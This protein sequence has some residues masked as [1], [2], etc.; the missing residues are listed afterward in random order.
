ME[1]KTSSIERV[2]KGIGLKRG[3]G[4]RVSVSSLNIP[5]GSDE[6]YQDTVRW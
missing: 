1:L 4:L 3:S 6:K 2:L 5:F